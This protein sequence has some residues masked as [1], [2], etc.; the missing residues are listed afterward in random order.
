MERLSSYLYNEIAVFLGVED[1]LSLRAVSKNS[2]SKVTTVLRYRQ[3]LLLQQCEEIKN[4]SEYEEAVEAQK[5]NAK[6]RATF[7][8]RLSK[9]H[10]AEMMY[11]K[12]PPKEVQEVMIL[13]AM[14][15]RRIKGPKLSWKEAKKIVR[16]K[17]PMF[18]MELKE[19][20]AN[21]LSDPVVR[22]MIANL[23]AQNI[24][25]PAI[26]GSLP[27]PSAQTLIPL[28]RNLLLMRKVE[29]AEE[30]AAKQRHRAILD[31]LFKSPK[32]V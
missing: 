11:I 6:I 15:A 18:M 12:N 13:A 19:L 27:S 30:F 28:F 25:Q 22:K 20:D 8:T 23:I 14:I 24:Y 10:Q 21:Y 16:C 1:L 32:A 29:G 17:K 3:H 9:P 26:L 2:R 4:S 5:E 31:K 7:H